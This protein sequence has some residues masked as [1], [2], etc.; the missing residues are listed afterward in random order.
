VYGASPAFVLSA[1]GED[2]SPD[3]FC[4]CLETITA[5]GF[6]AFQPEVFHR[7][8]LSEWLGGGALRVA[9]RARSLN[10][11]ASQFLAHFMMPCLASAA[12]LRSATGLEELKRAIELAACFEGCR[13]ITLPVGPWQPAPD[14]AEAYAELAGRF[15]DKLASMLEIAAAADFLLALEILPYS[16]AGGSEGFLRLQRD[17]GSRRLGLNFDTGH[18]WACREA[19][20][21]LPAKLAGLIFGTHLCDNEGAENLSLTPGEGTIDWPAV[22]ASLRAAGYAGS[23]DLEIRCPPEQVETV[24]GAG[25]RRLKE[26]EPFRRKHG[27]QGSP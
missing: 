22:L 8:R 14:D 7:E 12:S 11:A 20:H 5:L 2:F 23:L 16:F 1:R 10:L 3:D 4:A 26:L 27:A 25:L 21:L 15:R 19:L 24:Y 6:D 18:A 13:V 17:L 9:G